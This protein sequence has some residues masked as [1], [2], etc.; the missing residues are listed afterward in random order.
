MIK[1]EVIWFKM[2]RKTPRLIFVEPVKRILQPRVA[3]GLAAVVNHSMASLFDSTV[4]NDVNGETV[5]FLVGTHDRQLVVQ[6]T[7]A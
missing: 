2:A 5:G 6:Q 3:F 7:A 1:S 4:V